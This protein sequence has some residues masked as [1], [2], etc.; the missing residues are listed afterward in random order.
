MYEPTN[1]RTWLTCD[2]GKRHVAAHASPTSK[3]SC[4][5]LLGGRIWQDDAPQKFAAEEKP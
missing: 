5:R 4:G 1:I 3:C 2:C